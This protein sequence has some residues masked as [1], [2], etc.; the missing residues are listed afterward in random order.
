MSDTKTFNLELRTFEFARDC[1]FLV[2]DLNWSISNQ[3]DAKQLVRSYGSVG[4]IILKE[5]KS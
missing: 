2:Q 4:Q 3:D 5:M 1:W